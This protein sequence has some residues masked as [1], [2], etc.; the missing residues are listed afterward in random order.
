MP[1]PLP[2]G[3][4]VLDLLP[5]LADALAGRGPARLPVPADD[6]AA[7]A[8]LVD[9]LAG[10][11]LGP[12]EDDPADPTAFVVGTSGSTGPPKG[13]LLPVSA[14]AASAAA[15]TD[16]LAG[17]A[18]APGTWLL[19]VPPHHVAGLQVLLRSLVAGTEPVVLAPPFRADRFA[20]AVARLPAGP[21]YVSLVPTQLSR[22]LAD[23]TATAALATFTAVLVGGAA[24]DPVLLAAARTAGARVVTT[25]GMSETCGGCVYDGVPLAGVRAELLPGG[26][27][28]ATDGVG[29]VRLRG[30]VV[31]RGYRGRPAD[32]AF[33]SDDEGRWFATADLAR[34][35]T[36]G[37]LQVIGRVDDVLVT[38]GEKVHPV[39]VETA[40]AGVAGVGAVVVVGVPDARWGQRVVA[41][42]VTDGGDGPDEQ[43]IATAAR[44][45]GGRAAVPRMVLTIDELPLRGPGKPDRTALTAWAT[46]RVDRDG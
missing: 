41:V 44:T 9:A 1:L 13:A 31:A 34:W 6:P 25:Y 8:R 40:V 39:L 17:G 14:L 5:Q 2:P 38:G 46:Q 22:V 32:P 4:A 30:P 21:R 10:G 3:P 43:A 11:P 7:A 35:S 27:E 28:P 42:V 12:G 18:A 26:E 24:T 16:R 33:G 45:A 36:D 20:R 15:T 37:H 19:T 29:R 23:P